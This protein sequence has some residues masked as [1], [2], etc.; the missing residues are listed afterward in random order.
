VDE[1]GNTVVAL[2]AVVLRAGE[3]APAAASV[4]ED[5]F[6]AAAAGPVAAAPVPAAVAD[7]Q[8]SVSPDIEAA[9]VDAVA[10]GAGVALSPQGTLQVRSASGAVQAA[11]T[12][13][14]TGANDIS[15][16]VTIGAALLLAGTGMVLL[17]RRRGGFTQ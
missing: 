4:E 7:V 8:Q 6:Q 5:G 1:D 11:S 13:P 9:V 14:T 10:Q 12:L 17:R 16:Q 15:Q 2:V 3:A